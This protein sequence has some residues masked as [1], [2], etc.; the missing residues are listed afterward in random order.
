MQ[1]TVDL[2]LILGTLITVLLSVIAFFIKQLHTDFRKVEKDLT[3]VKTTTQLIKSEF[4]SSYDLLSQ[5]VTF[6]E[7]RIELIEQLNIN[8]HDLPNKKS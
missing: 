7:R 4:K 1:L 3:E 2:S 5:R 6:M 8:A